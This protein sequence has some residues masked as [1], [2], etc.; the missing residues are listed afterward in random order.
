VVK[1]P[2][3]WLEGTGR[4]PVSYRL[5]LARVFAAQGAIIGLTLVG[6]SILRPHARLSLLVVAAGFGL[7]AVA[8]VVLRLNAGVHEFVMSFY[9]I[10]VIGAVGW[11]YADPRLAQLAFACEMFTPVFGVIFMARRA[12]NCL[13]AAA[14]C[15]AVIGTIHLGGT[16]LEI[17]LRSLTV[18]MIVVLPGIMTAAYRERLFDAHQEAESAR[19]H[20][21]QL[22][23]LDPLTGLANRR[24]LAESFPD[25]HRAAQ[26]AGCLL[27]GLVL[28]VD[29]FKQVNDTFGHDVG[30]MVLA[31]V[32]AALMDQLRSDDIVVR[33]GGEEFGVVTAVDD[34]AGLMA[35]AERLRL[36]VA[37]WPS[38]R[39]VTISVGVSIFDPADLPADVPDQTLLNVNG[40]L[41]RL[42]LQADS[43]LYLAKTQGRNRTAG[44]IVVVLAE[45]PTPAAVA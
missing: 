23:R 24:G 25:R 35:L 6:G 9:L 37:A 32:A 44:P 30:D 42:M 12:I 13:C 18:L 36:T 40:P 20:A 41:T 2:R 28:D 45:E 16:L 17:S 21:E 8:A 3:F 22:S 31:E 11:E 33:L 38:Q 39:P 5:W 29:H 27:G 14:G 26:R 10:V 19:A 34:A 4:A 15:V 7:V 43:Q 1:A